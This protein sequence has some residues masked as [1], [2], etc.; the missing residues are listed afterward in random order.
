MGLVAAY[1]EATGD[2]ARLSQLVSVDPRGPRWAP[3]AT[4]TLLEGLR[5]G[6]PPASREE[7]PAATP[8]TLASPADL[9]E[10]AR[11]AVRAMAARARA[12]ATTEGGEALRVI[13][14][15]LTRG[16]A[17]TEEA[18]DWLRRERDPGL[19]GFVAG[20][21]ALEDSAEDER[22]LRRALLEHRALCRYAAA[23]GA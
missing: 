7:A 23:L 2:A 1:L 3:E 15:R 21:A 8:T 22:L 19:L 14:E 13:A 16:P 20:L 18:W 12:V 11:R 17:L 6:L 10:D 5:A 4:A 9:G